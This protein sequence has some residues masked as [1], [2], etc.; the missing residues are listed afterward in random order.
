V[1]RHRA[2]ERT[3][4]FRLLFVCTGNICRSPFAEILARHLLRG[5]LGGRAS[6][7]FDVSSAG[8]AAVVGAP[9]HPDSRAE[10]AP[11]HLD[12][13]PAEGFVARQLDSAMIEASDLV[14]GATARHRSAV[15]EQCPPALPI[16]FAMREFARLAASVDP[17]ELP[18]HPVARA[19]TLVDLARLRRGLVPRDPD[20]DDVP[21]PI[22][23]PVAA[24]HR[25]AQ[26]IQVAVTD[27]VDVVAPPV[28]RAE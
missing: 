7:P 27:L 21:D 9:M 2:E 3:D 19:H 11:W 1:G 12:G 13:A 26:L 23:G 24:H 8:I 25:A 4:V 22:A 14:L 16:T 28:R 20:G 5:R 18:G 10:L 15:I 6:Q 17:R